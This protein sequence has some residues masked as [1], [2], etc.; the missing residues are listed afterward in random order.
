MSEI[1]VSLD[2]ESTLAAVSAAFRDEYRERKGEEPE[3]WTDWGLGDSNVSVSDFME[4]T[5]SLWKHEPQTIEPTEQFIGPKVYG[6][7]EH[8]DSLDIVTGRRGARESLRAWLD[9]N[10]V[11]YDD[12]IVMGQGRSKADLDYDCY[13][14]DRPALAEDIGSSQHLFL[15]DQPYNQDV[16]ER[17]N[18]DRI[19]SL[20]AVRRELDRE[21]EV[22][23]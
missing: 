7:Y 16:A 17:R 12:L 18:V 2:I 3:M 20:G 13:V 10:G 6:I 8:A 23:A 5:Q 14:D 21:N 15:Y 9:M 11:V 4:I 22:I 1:T 19:Y